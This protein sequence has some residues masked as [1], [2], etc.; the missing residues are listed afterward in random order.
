MPQ[1]DSTPKICEDASSALVW[2]ASS[3]KVLSGWVMTTGL[4]CWAP[5][6][7]V[8]TSASWTKA[9]VM[10]TAVGMPR[11][12]SPTAS[13]KLHDV[14]D[15]QSPIAVTTTSV[16]AAIFSSSVSGASREK[17]AFV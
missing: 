5:S 8:C 16:S 13:C 9:A 7:A 15:P 17:L 2:I 1:C 4:S 11:V 14:Q 12:S 6:A 3:D 10:M